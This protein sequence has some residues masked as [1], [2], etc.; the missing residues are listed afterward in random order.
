MSNNNLLTPLFNALY[1][2]PRAIRNI[3]NTL[4]SEVEYIIPNKEMRLGDISIPIGITYGKQNIYINIGQKNV[5]TSIS[6]MSG[7]GKSNLLN[8]IICSITQLYPNVKLTLIDGKA[9]EL[10][11]YANLFNVES[12]HYKLEDISLAIEYVYNTIASTYERMLQEG[13]RQISIYEPRHVVI[14]D[15]ISLIDKKA[16][17]VLEKCM[18]L[19]RACG[20]HFIIC[21]QRLDSVNTITPVMK[22]LI[23]NIIT[24]KLDSNTSKLTIGTDEATQLSIPGRGIMRIEGQ[25]VKF[26]AYYVRQ[27][28]ID[29]VIIQNV[30]TKKEIP[31]INTKVININKNYKLKEVNIKPNTSATCNRNKEEIPSWVKNI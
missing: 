1:E 30:K 31:T 20:F 18:A 16:I 28:V 6:G 5:H 29:K 26:Q 2:V 13:V 3:C 8:S 4:P 23:D 25:T 12:F 14:I 9:V 7:Y 27:E 10:G 24:F 19:G 22:N 21:S 15:E 11:A 17:K